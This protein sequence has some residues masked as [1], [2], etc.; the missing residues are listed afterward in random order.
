MSTLAYLASDDCRPAYGDAVKFLVGGFLLWLP[1]GV[2]FLRGGDV[3]NNFLRLLC[4]VG[5]IGFA[6]GGAVACEQYAV[7]GSPDCR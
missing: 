5:I 4:L 2:T 6:V 1:G 3:S 7:A